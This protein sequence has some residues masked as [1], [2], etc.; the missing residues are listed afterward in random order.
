V[1]ESIVATIFGK[2]CVKHPELNG[3][4]AKGDCRACK[5]ER[6]KQ[7]YAENPEKVRARTRARAAAN[8]DKERERLR[9]WGAENLEK[10]RERGRK[11]RSEH[12]AEIRAAGRK[13]A[14]AN[15]AA[16]AANLACYRARKLNAAVPLTETDNLRIRKLYATAKARTKETGEEHHV[17]HDRPL[18]LGG[19]HHPDNLMVIPA[20]VNVRKGGRY[21]S[22]MDFLL[23]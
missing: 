6:G 20:A 5:R 2:V 13:W 17:D 14:V 1:V 10:E 12:P 15:P 9:R 23:S 3:E 11:R 18:A 22:T 21:K 19:K 8:P 16:R 4:R 7:H